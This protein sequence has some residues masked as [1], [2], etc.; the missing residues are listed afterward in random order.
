MQEV[1]ELYDLKKDPI[2]MNNLSGNPDYAEIET[3]LA[4]R[5]RR[6]LKDTGDPVPDNLA[7]LPKAGTI[8]FTGEAGP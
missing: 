1:D 6:W 3:D 4:Q 5:V 7:D 2:E 8:I